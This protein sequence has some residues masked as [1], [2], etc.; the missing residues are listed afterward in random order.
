MEDAIFRQVVAIGNVQGPSASGIRQ[1]KPSPAS[2]SKPRPRDYF[3]AARAAPGKG[4]GVRWG[5]WLALFLLLSVPAG[6]WGLLLL[7][8]RKKAPW[9]ADLASALSP[10]VEAVQPAA[11]PEVKKL[12]GK[13]EPDEAS[14]GGRD[15]YP[16]SEPVKGKSVRQML[17]ES[18]TLTL[19]KALEILRPVCEALEHAHRRNLPHPDIRP[20]NIMVAG[21][22]Q[23][24]LMDFAI[25]EPLPGTAYAAPELEKGVVR[26]EADVYA[27]GACLYEMLTGGP[28]FQPPV[29]RAQKIRMDFLPAS[30]L[31]PGLPA[32][33]D[34]AISQ[35]LQPSPDQRTKTPRQ[36]LAEIEEAVCP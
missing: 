27:L 1:Q 26:K 30:L 3:T 13:A 4:A 6:V 25:A 12:S 36:F 9:Q 21:P 19:A 24:K 8:K 18:R 16:A 17:A 29:S 33:I 11:M 7:N 15:I 22:G 31:A 34:A 2:E 28:P 5:P 23:A 14:K 35:A 32:K 20:S 10:R